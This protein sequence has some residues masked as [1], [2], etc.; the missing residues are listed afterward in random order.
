MTELDIKNGQVVSYMQD[1]DE[2]WRLVEWI[3]D[4]GIDR[5]TAI[6]PTVFDAN[7]TSA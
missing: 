2:G 4:Q 5:I 6:E 3:D 1:D 7:F